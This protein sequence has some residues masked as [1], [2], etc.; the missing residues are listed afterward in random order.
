MYVCVYD[1]HI[2]VLLPFYFFKVPKGGTQSTEWLMK[3]LK[4]N[5]SEPFQAIQVSHKCTCSSNVESIECAIY[6]CMLHIRCFGMSCTEFKVT[7]EGIR[8]SGRHLKC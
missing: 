5:I 8:F 2:P 4:S 6:T 3:Q 1:I 7:N